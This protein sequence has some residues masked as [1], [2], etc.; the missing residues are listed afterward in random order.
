M[1]NTD[2]EL[3]FDLVLDGD[4]KTVCVLDNNC[5]AKQTCGVGNICPVAATYDQALLYAQ[6]IISN[7]ESVT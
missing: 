1:L 6:V 4:G 3:F 7:S 2:F 5:V